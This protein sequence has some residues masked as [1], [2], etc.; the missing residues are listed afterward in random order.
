LLTAGGNEQRREQQQQY[1]SQALRRAGRA[2]LQF[3]KS[4][5]KKHSSHRDAVAAG[6]VLAPALSKGADNTV[7]RR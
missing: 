2:A 1:R 4:D 6:P 3:V 5:G 7:D